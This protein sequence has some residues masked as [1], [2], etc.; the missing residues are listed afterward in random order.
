VAEKP[1]E[2]GSGEEAP[3]APATAPA[4]VAKQ[5]P[6][7]GSSLPVPGAM[8]AQDQARHAFLEA[9]E[10][11]E[12]AAPPSAAGGDATDR[13][14]P[15]TKVAQ[16]AVRLAK[17]SLAFDAIALAEQV[18]DVLLRLDRLLPQSE[19]A[20]GPIRVKLATCLV[21]P[22]LVERG[23]MPTS[24]PATA[25]LNERRLLAAEECKDA[26]KQ[27][28]QAALFTAEPKLQW[29]SYTLSGLAWE[30][31]YYLLAGRRLDDEAAAKQNAT[32]MADARKAAGADALK[33]L[34]GSGA[35]DRKESPFLAPALLLQARLDA[36]K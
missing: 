23:A 11:L 9:Q 36:I 32:D 27:F 31:A 1:A 26:A 24:G 34:T 6:A 16:G 8:A 20:Q 17:A 2:V 13:P 14:R 29:T 35:E 25:D 30:K 3:A 28:E 18:Q 7:A 15:E 21:E 5:A 22:K 19:L 12:S 4:T 10:A 33:A